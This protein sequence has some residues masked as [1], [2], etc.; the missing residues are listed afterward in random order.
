MLKY[1]YE[2]RKG[3]VRHLFRSKSRALNFAK[4][5]GGIFKKLKRPIMST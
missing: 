1:K 4:R 5:S 3:L 2:L